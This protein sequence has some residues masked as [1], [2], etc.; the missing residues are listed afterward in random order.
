LSAW[1]IPTVRRNPGTGSLMG[2]G[3]FEFISI[4]PSR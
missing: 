4:A 1:P 2:R 3:I